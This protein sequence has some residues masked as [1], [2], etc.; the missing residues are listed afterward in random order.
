MAALPIVTPFDVLDREGLYST[1]TKGYLE[2]ASQTYKKGTPLVVT[3]AGYLGTAV[4]ANPYNGG[5][6]VGISVAAGSNVAA[7]AADPTTG[8]KYHLMFPISASTIEFIGQLAASSTT[9]SVDTHTLAQT[10]LWARYGITQD[11]TSGLWYVNFSDTTDIY[12]VITHL[13]DPIGTVSGR[14]GF[15]MMLTGGKTIYEV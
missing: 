5:G 7:G 6:L 1:P 2:D 3:T 10:D 9:A 8:D 15:K 4:V 12:V 14:V 13:I 11:V